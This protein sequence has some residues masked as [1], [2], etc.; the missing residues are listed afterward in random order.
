MASPAPFQRIGVAGLGLIGGSVALAAKSIWPDVVVHG[1]DAAAQ[2]GDARARG[3]V[4]DGATDIAALAGCDLIVL[5][6]PLG[7]MQ[8]VLHALGRTRTDAVVTDVGST[9]RRIVATAK[10]V[11]LRQFV[12]GHPMAGGE[13]PGL[14]QARA[15][16]FADRP[17]LLVDGTA[18]ADARARV[19]AFARG[20]GARP[21]W[22]DADAH[23]RTVAYV[24]HLPQVV[25]TALM[26]S[27]DEALGIG[28]KAA[29][30]PAFAEM[31]RLASSPPDMWTSVL[32]ENADFV[33]EA[34]AQFARDMPSIAD[35][36]S[37]AW[38]RDVLTRAGQARARW[39]S[40]R[41]R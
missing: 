36:Q 8:D 20:L 13:R 33:A 35:L 5:A 19:E 23:D 25:A 14:D 28:G 18:D 12:G 34:L 9:K 30:G 15:D 4:S 29:A 11:G 39:R 22:M 32:A 3:V 10:D 7:S 40:A 26:T 37:G 16:L 31:T 27:A 21:S 1:C 41:E 38:A 17:W 24:S 2:V 6:V